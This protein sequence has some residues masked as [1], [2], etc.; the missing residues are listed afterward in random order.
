MALKIRADL[1]GEAEKAFNTLG[2]LLMYALGRIPAPA[3][4]V[5]LAGLRFEVVDMDGNGVDKVLI[6]HRVHA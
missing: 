1:P 5:E 4:Y 6:V 3:D 2:G